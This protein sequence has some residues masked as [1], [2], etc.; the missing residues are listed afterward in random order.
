MSIFSNFINLNE[1]YTNIE[2]Y[3]FIHP[4][5]DDM[6]YVFDTYTFDYCNTYDDVDFF[7]GLPSALTYNGLTH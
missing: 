3:D 4:W 6:P 7:S 1:T 5:N 2:L